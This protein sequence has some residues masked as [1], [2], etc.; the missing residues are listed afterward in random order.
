MTSCHTLRQAQNHFAEV[1]RE[2]GHKFQNVAVA[3]SLLMRRGDYGYDAPYALVIFGLLAVASGLGAAVAW[4]QGPIRAAM[5]I[6]IYFV[7]FLVLLC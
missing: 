4:L 7:F 6:T 3:Y 1:D 2:V 5:P